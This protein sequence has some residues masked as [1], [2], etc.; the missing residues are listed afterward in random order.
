MQLL[1]GR[2]DSEAARSMPG[3][4]LLPFLLLSMRNGEV[5]AEELR[6]GIDELGF[7]HINTKELHE[8]LRKMEREGLISSGW[9]APAPG[10]P[11]R[12]YRLAETGRAYLE[13]WSDSLQQY[14]EEM[15]VFFELYRGLP[16]QGGSL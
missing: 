10:L 1:K 12:R 8:T 6:G 3:S 16:Y 7:R 5:Y 14:R 13:F 9:D 4:W 15:D 2:R 11:R